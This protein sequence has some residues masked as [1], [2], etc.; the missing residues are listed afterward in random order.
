MRI[1]I[2]TA[3]LVATLA[4]SVQELPAAFLIVSGNSM[5]PFARSGQIVLVNRYVYRFSAPDAGDVVA[6]RTPD[7]GELAMKRV[8]AVAPGPRYH[9]VGDNHRDSL[10]SRHFG[11]ISRDAIIGRVESL[12]RR[13]SP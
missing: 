13:V 5:Y 10:D 9:L 12:G 1:I 7:S 6:F 3:L 11:W 4:W 2:V 8:S